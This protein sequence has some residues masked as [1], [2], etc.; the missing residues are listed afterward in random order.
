[1]EP[2]ATPRGVLKRND[3]AMPEAD[4]QAMLATAFCGR[5]GTLGLDGYPYV[6]PNL[7]TWQDG[8]VYLHTAAYAGHF[9]T[10]VR[11]HAQACF[12]LD[13]PGT[14]FPYGPV[15]CDTSVAYRSVILFGQIRIVADEDEQRRFYRAFMEKYAPAASWGRPRDAFPRMHGTIVYA[16]TPDRITGKQNMLP[17]LDARW[18]AAPPPIAHTDIAAAGE[19]SAASPHT[20]AS[21]EPNL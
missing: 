10:N 3:K 14:I 17:P 2:T 11:A 4:I 16:I 20:P 7:F 21:K 6:V 19:P 15:A 12:E 5:I 8:Q 1:M 13:E 9:L 18:T